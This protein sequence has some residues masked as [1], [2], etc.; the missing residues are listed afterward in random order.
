MIKHLLLPKIQHMTDINVDL[1]QWFIN[2]LI[3][4]TVPLVD[5]STSGGTVKNEIRSNKELAEELH[6][7][8]ITKFEERILHSSF[9]EN[10][11]GLDIGIMQF[12]STFDEGFR[13]YY[14]L[15]TFIANMHGSFL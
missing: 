15:S 1:F 5:K 13:F 7:P 12:I 4:E 6:K 8:I 14:V 3:K 11:W 10:I 9:I 2:F